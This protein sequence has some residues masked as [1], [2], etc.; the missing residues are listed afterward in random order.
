MAE[1]EVCGD[2]IDS[3]AGLECEDCGTYFCSGSCERQHGCVRP[4]EDTS[5]RITPAQQALLDS[6][7]A[8]S[9]APSAWRSTGKRAG[10]DNFRFPY[11]NKGIA[12]V[13]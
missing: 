8:P 7:P 11:Q 4:D 3:F 1:C 9:K 12:L 2:R 5:P 13:M 10:C 6:W